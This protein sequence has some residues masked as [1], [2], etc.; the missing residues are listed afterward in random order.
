MLLTVTDLM[1]AK[2]YQ[3][4]YDWS[5]ETVVTVAKK[6]DGTVHALPRL[7]GSSIRA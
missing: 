7:T 4:E 6:G 3:H 5:P 2:D 1:L